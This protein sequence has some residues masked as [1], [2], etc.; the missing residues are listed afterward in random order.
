MKTVG[1]ILLVCL[2]PLLFAL[3]FLLIYLLWKAMQIA[4]GTG[5]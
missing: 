4:L 3:P 2:F 1:A 5:Y